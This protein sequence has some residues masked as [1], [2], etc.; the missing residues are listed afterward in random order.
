MDLQNS[1]PHCLRVIY[2][3]CLKLICNLVS[4]VTQW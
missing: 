3:F 4:Q 2:T 1:E